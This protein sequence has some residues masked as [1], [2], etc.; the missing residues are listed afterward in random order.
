MVKESNEKPYKW[1][2][3]DPEGAKSADV[4]LPK[5]NEIAKILGRILI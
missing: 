4:F 3:I 1:K 5:P 2:I